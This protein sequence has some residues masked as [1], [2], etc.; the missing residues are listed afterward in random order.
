[1]KYC[2]LLLS[3]AFCM[4]SCHYKFVEPPSLQIIDSARSYMPIIQGAEM[5]IF[6][7]VKNT[8]KTA[9]E[10][11]DV[12]PSNN[13]TEVEIVDKTIEPGKY[14]VL[15]FNFKPGKNLLGYVGVY[16]TLVTN[17]ERKHHDFFFETTVVQ[18]ENELKGYK[19]QGH[20]IYNV[21]DVDNNM[22]AFQ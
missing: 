11:E 5:E 16:N 21:K 9:L 8:G 2:Y 1:M 13:A 7:K 10:I 17:T 15:R 4:Q 19:H 14:G 20:A 6:V 22:A 12:L 18:D 3:M